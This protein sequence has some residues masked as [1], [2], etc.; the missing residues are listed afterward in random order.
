MITVRP[1]VDGMITSSRRRLLAHLGAG[2]VDEAAL[3]ME[4][5][6][7][8]LHYMWRLARWSATPSPNAAISGALDGNFPLYVWQTY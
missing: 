1:A 2:H 4:K 5:H 7:R 8:R 6:L 3:E